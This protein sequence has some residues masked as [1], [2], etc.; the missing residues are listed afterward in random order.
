M[1]GRY[2]DYDWRGIAMLTQ[3]LGQ[4]FEPSKTRLMSQQQEHEMNML[5]AKQSWTM[6]HKEV[7]RLQRAYDAITEEYETEKTKVEKL[8]S[9]DLVDAGL[10]VGANIDESMKLLE[11][12]DFR[13]VEEL[14]N[15]A[16]DYR[17]MI[18]DTQDGIDN[19]ESYNLH[20]IMGQDFSKRMTSMPGAKVQKEYDVLAESDGIPGLS[21]KEKQKALNMYLKDTGLI[22]NEDDQNY[23]TG[24]NM[25]IWDGANYEDLKVSP[26]GV[27][28]VSGYNA[29]LD[30]ETI[31]KQKLTA[32]A[33]PHEINWK[34]LSPQQITSIYTDQVNTVKRI[35]DKYTLQGKPSIGQYL[36]VVGN[37]WVAKDIT[38]LTAY[39]A[40][41]IDTYIGARNTQKTV[42]PHLARRKISPDIDISKQGYVITDE[43]RDFF[44]DAIPGMPI[45]PNNLYKQIESKSE[46]DKYELM[47]NSYEELLRD[48]NKTDASRR[49]QVL[50]ILSNWIAE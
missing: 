39:D 33:Q 42:L 10:R 19:Y 11:M 12:N 25:Q 37:D 16:N 24:I 20:G 6:Q 50:N 45:D 17:Q 4:L 29:T 14:L 7:E 1:A 21:Y 5:M 27:A 31:A 48:Y 22:L 15:T 34:D 36:H 46:D 9:E 41:D 3:Q 18:R 43:M 28:F 26:E 13:K 38:A 23:N 30:K 44:K 49:K 2:P 32:S 40:A 35:N 8:G 47:V